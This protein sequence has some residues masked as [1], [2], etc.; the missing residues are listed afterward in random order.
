M[1]FRTLQQAGYTVYKDA[2]TGGHRIVVFFSVEEGLLIS[3]YGSLGLE[4]LPTFY[5]KKGGVPENGGTPKTPQN[6]H[7]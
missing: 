3:H 2:S 4:Y 1:P 6:D 7:F 5:H